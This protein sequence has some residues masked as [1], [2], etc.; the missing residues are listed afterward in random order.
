[1]KKYYGYFRAPKTTN[2]KRQRQNCEYSRAKRRP[3]NLP[4]TWDDLPVRARDQKSWKHKRKTQY[5]GPKRGEK[6]S[7]TLDNASYRILWNLEEYFED[8]DIPFDIEQNRE[9]KMVPD[10]DYVKHSTGK[11]NMFGWEICYHERVPNGKLR[12]YTYTVSHT[13][14]WWSNKDIGLDYIL[15]KGY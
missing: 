15:K 5:R 13:V 10:F 12:K 1:M 8:H 14:T 2:E 7:I 6:H 3:N 11:K 9:S 4:D